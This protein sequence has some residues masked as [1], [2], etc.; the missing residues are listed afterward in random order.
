MLLKLSDWNLITL[1]ISNLCVWLY[2]VI[3]WRQLHIKCKSNTNLICKIIQ[4][5]YDDLLTSG[6]RWRPNGSGSFS[7][8]QRFNL[9]FLTLQVLTLQVSLF[10]HLLKNR[11][12]VHFPNREVIVNRS[13][14]AAAEKTSPK[15]P[16]LKRVAA[17]ATETFGY[18]NPGP[19]PESPVTTIIL[20]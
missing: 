16:P 3:D 12:S 10:H 2:F 1:F 14:S 7:T 9:S 4:H 18:F 8:I 15:T 6:G 19:R 11:I 13:W 5:L 20:F 17:V